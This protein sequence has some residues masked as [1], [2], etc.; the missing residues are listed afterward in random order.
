[1]QC[2]CL[3]SL[4]TNVLVTVDRDEVQSRV[5]EGGRA[6]SEGLGGTVSEGNAASAPRRY[7]LF[8]REDIW[9]GDKGCLARA[10]FEF[11]LQLD[12]VACT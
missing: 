12:A 2:Q 10:I 8:P 5:V 4:Q 7:G 9:D 3:F 6:Q 11:L 1:M